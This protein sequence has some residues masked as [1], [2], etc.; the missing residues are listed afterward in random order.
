MS[1]GTLFLFLEPGKAY[2]SV[3]I[4]VIFRGYPV[5]L[6]D[7]WKELKVDSTFVCFSLLSTKAFCFIF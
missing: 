3:S 7:V 6:I 2:F 1:K 4:S 5:L